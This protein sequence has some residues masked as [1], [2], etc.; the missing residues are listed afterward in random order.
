M[1][2]RLAAAVAALLVAPQAS[3][4]PKPD[5]SFRRVLDGLCARCI[6]PANTGGRV[7]DLAVVESGP[8]TFY[9]AAATGGV[10][11]TTDGGDTF[12]PVFDQ[13]PTLSIGAVAV[14]QGKPG[15]VY[16]A[17]GEGNPRNSV[18][19]GNGVYKSADGGKTWTHCGLADTYHIGRVVVH[20]TDPDVA[21]VAAIGHLWGPNKERGLFKTTDGGKTWWLSKFV[22]ENTGFVDVA[23]DP[24]DPET[25]YAAAWQVRRDAFSGGNPITQTGPTGGLFKTTN[26]GKTWAKM[27][28][29]LPERPYGRCGV[30]VYHKD[31]KIVYAVVQTDKTAVT[32]IGQPPSPPGKGGKRGPLGGPD[33]GGVFRSED[34]GQTWNK[35]NDLVPRPFYYGKIRVDPTNDQ[36]VYVLGVMLY[37][38][39][40]AG[41]TFVA[42]PP[43]THAD[44]H[45]LWVNPANPDHM[46]LGNDG[47]LFVTRD[48]G[49]TFDPKRGLV[50]GQ[51][52]GI[53]V[54]TRIPYR[55][56]G[57]LQDNGSW[58]GPV[59]TPYPDGITLTDWHRV[60]GG[61]G[62]QCAVDPADPDTVY[63]EF[64][65]GSLFRMRMTG[66]KGP[67]TRPVR[68]PFPRGGPP[69]RFNWNT[70]LLLSPHDPKTIYYGGNVL[71]RS[72]DRGDTWAR[73]SPDLTRATKFPAM[74]GGHTLT[75][76]AESPVQAGVLWVGTDDGKVWVSRNGGKEWSDVGKSIP[77]IP[78]DGWVTRAEC[79]HSDLG[80][81]YVS[82][83]RH[84]RD[85]FGP[86]I[87]ATTDYGTTWKPIAT[88]LPAGA[89][90]RVVRQ[91]SRNRNLLFAGTERGLYVSP[92]DGA[93]WHL[94]SRSGLPAAVR[95]DDLVI[96]PRD[97][98]LVI[99]TH[100]RGM[101]VMDISPL[102]QLT[103]KILQA[104]AHLFDVKP[105][106]LLKAQ[107][108][109]PAKSKGYVAKNPPAGLP[110]Y[111]LTT[112]KSAGD[113]LVS[114]KT[115]EGK[116]VGVYKGSG[117]AGLDWCTFDVRGPG[118][119]SVT[120]QACKNT[121][122]QTKKTTVKTA[123]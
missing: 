39:T 43:L 86:Y 27:L 73:I 91:S 81:V 56:Y 112:D 11:K 33:V 98:D 79:S 50:I 111:F 15:V 68:P 23:M 123:E 34:R 10:W 20:P 2:L 12:T 31:P 4:G 108:R 36:R 13:Q 48:G 1:S 92:D 87:F 24:T 3:A 90:V 121:I 52:Y 78:P 57:G 88:G 38:S 95:I 110:V 16:V 41:S 9:V 80:T 93:N 5:D 102:E 114:C 96:H 67:T 17:T 46:I 6:G 64:Q 26:G 51:F 58:G 19:P 72:A 54:D 49:K 71:F 74:N 69:F 62:F 109:G 18:S 60:S 118:E 107:E 45:A 53:A 66:E 14:C 63:T 55:V 61:D 106:T 119:Y 115:A 100:G 21:Y 25:V 28:G 76:I 8:D 37:A 75:T 7:V 30:T 44:H 47:G 65:Y 105:V 103:E 120:L 35:L 32:S 104:D 85:D 99:G 70:P 84:R 101:W 94:L 122:V 83:D 82:I 89:V 97:R 22:D 117:K 42:R 77:G 29:G 116:A 113:V 59:A 40:D